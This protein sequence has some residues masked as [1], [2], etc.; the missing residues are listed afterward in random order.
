MTNEEKKHQLYD[1][2][3]HNGFDFSVQEIADALKISGRALYYRY[4]SKEEMIMDVKNY[5]KRKWQNDFQL[6][7]DECNHPV[8]KL[9]IFITCLQESGRRD[10]KFLLMEDE[11][12]APV[13]KSIIEEGIDKNY[14]KE[15]DIDAFVS[16]LCFN[17]IHYF[18]SR[19]KEII[20]VNYILNSLLTKSGEIAYNEIN[21]IILNGDKMQNPC[22]EK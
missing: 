18:I 14:F 20:D 21:M 11:A 4:H 19:G 3:N 13:L 6:R 17:L 10:L 22:F 12:F 9:V 5:W 2:F 1:F 8:E 15:V 16:L 7:T